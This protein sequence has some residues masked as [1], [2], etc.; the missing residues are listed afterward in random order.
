MMIDPASSPRVRC[1]QAEVAATRLHCL[2]ED[3]ATQPSQLL[4]QQQKWLCVGVSSF[5]AA[6][7]TLVLSWTKKRVPGTETDWA[8]SHDYEAITQL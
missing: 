6:I 8:P 1:F 3:T 4:N 5:Q 7:L 2:R